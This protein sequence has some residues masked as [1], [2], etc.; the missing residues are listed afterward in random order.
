MK[1]FTSSVIGAIVALALSSAAWAQRPPQSD[2]EM[3]LEVVPANS[4]ADAAT[5]EIKLP[6]SVP[7]D[8]PAHDASKFG[9]ETANKARELGT[10]FGQDV[11]NAARAAKD[12][13]AI[14]PPQLPTK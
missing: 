8:S 4:S 2:L 7:A 1:Q 13:P 3:T 12:R 5:G 9:L 6:E 11:S 10:K 14:V